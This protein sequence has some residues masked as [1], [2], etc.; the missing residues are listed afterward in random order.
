MVPWN[1]NDQVTGDH[2]H[3]SDRRL[4]ACPAGYVPHNSKQSPNSRI[5]RA[6]CS[7]QVSGTRSETQGFGIRE[8]KHSRPPKLVSK[9]ILHSLELF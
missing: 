9:I 1:G 5:S 4:T 8:D 7:C 2:R 3:H 6:V